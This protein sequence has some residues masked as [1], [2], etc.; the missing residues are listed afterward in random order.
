MP[1]NPHDNLLINGLSSLDPK[2]AK[3][4]DRRLQQRLAMLSQTDLLGHV[5]YLFDICASVVSLSTVFC[6]LP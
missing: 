5:A 6:R 4:I 3:V 1:M 2:V